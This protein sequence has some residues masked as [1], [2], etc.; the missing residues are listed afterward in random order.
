MLYLLENYV[1]SVYYNI[2]PLTL[3]FQVQFIKF[4][5]T[6]TA[7]NAIKYELKKDQLSARWEKDLLA[8]KRKYLENPEMKKKQEV[9]K[10]Y[11]DNSKAIRQDHKEKYLMNR[12][13]TLIYRKA[14]YQKNPEV[15]LVY[16]KCQYLEIPEMK[17][18]YQK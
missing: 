13:S 4:P 9:K 15:Q 11:D 7:K 1:K 10:R 17:K 8:K 5:C 14:K 3:Y 12:A 16:K 2:F 18:D 6:A